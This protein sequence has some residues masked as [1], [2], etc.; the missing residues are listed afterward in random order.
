VPASGNIGAVQSVVVTFSVPMNHASL[1]ISGSLV[2]STN[3]A[4]SWASSSV[5]TVGPASALWPAGAQTLVIDAS[6]AEGKAMAAPLTL[7]FA[8]DLAANCPSA[9][10]GACVD[11]TDCAF[12]FTQFATFAQTCVATPPYDT[13]AAGVSA[14]VHASGPSV[15]CSDCIGSYL[16]C[17]V[18]GSCAAC[19]AGLTDPGCITCLDAHGCSAAFRTCSGR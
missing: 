12:S 15:A 1:A 16:H 11:V 13:S 10:A 14:C 19:Q 5:L 6:S 7:A 18:A 3:A 4:P 8:V 2:A 9:G 17:A